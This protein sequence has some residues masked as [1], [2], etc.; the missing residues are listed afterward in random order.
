[1][2]H[3]ALR[4]AR[5]MVRWNAAGEPLGVADFRKL[6]VCHAG[7]AIAIGAF[8]VP[9]RISRPATRSLCD[10]LTRAAMSV[11]ANI[12]EGSA[13]SSSREFARFLQ[14]ALASASELES[15]LRL[16]RDL[17][18]IEEIEFKGLLSQIV[19]ARRMLHGLPKTVKS[20]RSRS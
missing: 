17:Q 6:R 5:M 16:A 12:A 13:H 14:Y 7:Q 11:P 10:Q 1:M 15:H 20:R 2:K 4:C 9:A 19:D 8:H 18:L 3:P